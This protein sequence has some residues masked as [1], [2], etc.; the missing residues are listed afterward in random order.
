MNLQNLLKGNI[1]QKQHI[2]RWED[3]I[4]IL[5]KPLLI[6]GIITTSYLDAVIK[7]I[8]DYGTYMVLF[9]Y[10][11]L[12][13]ARPEEGSLK[14]GLSF[15]KLDE[16]VMFLDKEVKYFLLLSTASATEHIQLIQAVGSIFSDEDQVLEQLADAKT[17]QDILDIFKGE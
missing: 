6:Q 15:L 14:V 10:F 4:Y 9:D 17:E 12:P 1:I 5:G 8:H 16:S 7:N 13:H 2:A 3:A 11:A